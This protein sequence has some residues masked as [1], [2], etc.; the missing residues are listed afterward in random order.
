VASLF[1][2]KAISQ[3]HANRNWLCDVYFF[4]ANLLI[5]MLSSQL[6]QTVNSDNIKSLGSVDNVLMSYIFTIAEQQMKASMTRLDFDA[7]GAMSCKLIRG[8]MTHVMSAQVFLS[9]GAL[10]NYHDRLQGPLV[11][12]SHVGPG[13]ETAQRGAEQSSLTAATENAMV[14]QE[15]AAAG[16]AS[17]A[18]SNIGN[19]TISPTAA[20]DSMAEV[21]QYAVISVVQ[22]LSYG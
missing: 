18:W 9:Q 16:G 8:L 19:S 1:I 5:S 7:T 13:G 6:Y 2:S 14:S 3:Y 11:V 22:S 15:T 10:L 17:N 4:G 21:T 12:T 20:E